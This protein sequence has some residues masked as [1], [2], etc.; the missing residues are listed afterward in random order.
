VP[1][2]FGRRA[3]VDG[4]LAEEVA[5]RQ[6]YQYPPFRHL[7]LQVFRGPNAE[8]VAFFAEH[9]A[10]RVTE[11]AGDTVELRGPAPCPVEK[12]KDHYRYQIWFFTKQVTKFV[13]LLNRLETDFQLPDDVIAT[14]DVDPVSTV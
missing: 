5:A 11:A 10:R 8:K 9:W 2:Q 7:I 12:I 3:D 14:L 13:A 1:V 4:F 6:Q